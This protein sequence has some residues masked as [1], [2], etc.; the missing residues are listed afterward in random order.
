M[1]A[2]PMPI[3][4][5][6]L[7]MSRPQPT[8]MLLPQMPMPVAIRYVTHSIS[9]LTKN[10]EMPN[11]IHQPRV[12]PRVSTIALILSVTDANVCPG[13]STGEPRRAE[14]VGHCVRFVSAESSGHRLVHVRARP[15]AGIRIAESRQVRRSRL[16]AEFADDA[17]VARVGL[18]LGD[19]AVGVVD[20]A[21]DDR[22]RS[23][24]PAGRRSASVPSAIVG[25]SPAFDGV[26]LGVD[27]G[28]VD[29]LHAVGALLHHAAAADRHVGVAQQ[30]V[31]PA[32]RRP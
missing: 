18:Q 3:H 10:S 28:G 23:G 14:V 9:T 26:L 19:A 13:A 15:R 1:P 29:P 5:T 11:P 4:Q 6:K 12:V 31:A 30:F 2:W 17:V 32:G 16:R 21:E 27:P 24:T 8:G 7:R 25:G 20:V 22:L